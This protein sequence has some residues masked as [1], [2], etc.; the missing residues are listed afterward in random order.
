VY[1]I[2]LTGKSQKGD[3]VE[4]LDSGADDYLVK[5]F[6]R[7]ELKARLTAG[8]RIIELQERLLVAQE[9]LREQATHDALTGAFNRA[10]ILE[11]LQRELARSD[12]EG[13]PLCL[14]MVDI[15]HFKSINDSFGH[16]AGD[17]VLRDIIKRLCSAMRPYDSIGRY[18][19]EEFLIV[20]PG[21]DLSHSLTLA[22][23]LRESIA[24]EHFRADSHT[25]P[26]TVSLGLTV[27]EDKGSADSLIRAADE[28]LYR[29][30]RAG[31]NRIE[32]AGTVDQH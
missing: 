18:G 10:A 24:H 4:G 6:D 30:K 22:E 11:I 20:A 26:V 5:P 17:A 13:R 3:V 9:A 19:G 29:A 28:A 15:D 7:S 1:V 2:L 27:C 12:R 25:I 8:A 21:C 16:S 31:R 23:R 32:V 14:S